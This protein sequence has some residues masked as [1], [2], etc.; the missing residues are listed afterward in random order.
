MKRAIALGTFAALVFVFFVGAGDFKIFPRTEP[1][2]PINVFN[3][4]PAQEPGEEPVTLQI[5]VKPGSDLPYQLLRK[6]RSPTAYYAEVVVLDE[7]SR[8]M[9][10]V[11]SV[12]VEPGSHQ[13]ASG[14]LR[15]GEI[16]LDVAVDHLSTRAMVEATVKKN[17][18]IVQRQ[19][20]DVM[21]R[22]SPPPGIIPVR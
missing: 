4:V 14:K 8:K 11:A 3:G 13:S 12:F 21:L 18:A 9:F 1:A 17:G 19:K 22:V 20:S 6:R 15:N 16:L 2:P 5:S 10:G 7:T